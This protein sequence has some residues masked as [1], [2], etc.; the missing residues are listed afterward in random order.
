MAYQLPLDIPFTVG[1]LPLELQPHTT[2]ANCNKVVLQREAL[3]T[4]T[5]DY[6]C[7]DC[8]IEDRQ[9]RLRREGM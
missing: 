5:E 2:C 8:E 7:E 1:E 9:R 3:R 4:K 6:C